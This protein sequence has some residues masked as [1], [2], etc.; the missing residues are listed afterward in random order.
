MLIFAPCLRAAGGETLASTGPTRAT[1]VALAA[2]PAK[3]SDG[4]AGGGGEPRSTLCDAA[5]PLCHEIVTAARKSSQ[6]DQGLCC[7]ARPSLSPACLR[8]DWPAG[9]SP[10]TPSDTSTYLMSYPHV[11]KQRE[12]L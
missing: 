6:T 9:W 2:G 10:P 12:E 3:V 1:R 7:P 5:L 4:Q 11:Y 8:S